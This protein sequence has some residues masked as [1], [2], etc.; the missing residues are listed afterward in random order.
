MKS[1]TIGREE[2]CSIVIPDSSQMVSRLHA[3][4]NVDGGKMTITDSSS[5]GT[6]INGIRISSGMPVPVT[7]KD[8]VTFAQVAEL[9]WKQI[10]NTGLRTLWITL[11]TVLVLA[12]VGC[13]L[14]FFLQD[15]K[16]KKE[17][18]AAD[19]A[20]AAQMLTSQVD[21]LTSAV[22]K[23]CTAYDALAKEV[24]DVTQACAK[25][26]P[27]QLT[28]VSKILGQV[29]EKMKAVDTAQ[30][31]KSLDSVMQ[32][33]EDGSEKTGQRMEE[34]QKEVASSQ[35]ALDAAKEQLGIA[36]DLLAKIPDVKPAAKKPAPREKP[37]AEPEEQPK[38]KRIF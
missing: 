30:L 22:N 12:A 4:L 9:D 23:I 7:R 18:A 34:L 35:T 36:K 17:Q 38:D 24:E 8:V 29:E 1:Y 3:T 15:S 13:G 5:N 28:E 10:P 20:A 26:A 33:K 25:K 21:S 27:S 6:Y 16:K 37:V 2:T 31:R 32:S 11:A 14:W 19:E